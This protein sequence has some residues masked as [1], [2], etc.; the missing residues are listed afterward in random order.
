MSDDGGLSDLA[1]Q[2]ILRARA[3]ISRIDDLLAAPAEPI[4]RKDTNEPPMGLSAEEELEWWQTR[5]A[6]LSSD[7]DAKAIVLPATGGGSGDQKY[8]SKRLES[9]KQSSKGSSRCDANEILR[10]EKRMAELKC[11]SKNSSAEWQ[12][13]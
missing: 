11:E 2:A 7:A 6:A 13:K 4:N 3:S 9:E 10:I 5:I 12:S 1:M 8:A